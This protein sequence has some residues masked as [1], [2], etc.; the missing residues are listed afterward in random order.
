MTKNKQIMLVI[1]L[2]VMATAFLGY[3]YLANGLGLTLEA[4]V[5]FILSGVCSINMYFIA[6]SNK[7]NEKN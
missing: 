6:T 1:F 4:F 3:G 7:F 5:W 2:V